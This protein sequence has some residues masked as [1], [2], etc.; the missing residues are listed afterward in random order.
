[1][2]SS[3]CARNYLIKALIKYCTLLLLPISGCLSHVCKMKSQADHSL[4]LMVWYC[5]A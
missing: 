5:G 2:Y 1:M 3:Q 4:Y